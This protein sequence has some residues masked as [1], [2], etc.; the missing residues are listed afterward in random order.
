MHEYQK[1][2]REDAIKERNKEISAII[3]KLGD[4]TH[5]T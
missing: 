2:L 4:E 5:D 1:K 3:E